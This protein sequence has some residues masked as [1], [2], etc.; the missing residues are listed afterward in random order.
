[1]QYSFR[2]LFTRNFYDYRMNF[3]RTRELVFLSTKIP[4]Q[5]YHLTAFK[6]FQSRHLLNPSSSSRLNHPACVIQKRLSSSQISQVYHDQEGQIFTL[7]TEGHRAYLKYYSLSSDTVNLASTVVPPELGG[8]GVA[9][10]LA[11][12][13]FSWAVDNNLKMKLSCWYLSGYLKRHPRKEVS[14]LVI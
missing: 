3:Q 11:D 9:K 13:A 8:R 6:V 7:D 14:D 2:D 1:M 5:T 4:R 10:I 12:A